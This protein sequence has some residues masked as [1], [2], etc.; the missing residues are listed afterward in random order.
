MK[1]QKTKNKTLINIVYFLLFVLIIAWILMMGNNSFFKKWKLSQKAK[2]T[3]EEL[4]YL[5]A[6]NDSLKQE[7][8]RLHSDPE[9]Q[10]LHVKARTGI[11]EKGETVYIFKPAEKDSLKKDKPKKGK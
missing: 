10:K 2:K 4:K 7:N 8:K 5:S 3:E 6:Q 1:T 11:Y 9:E